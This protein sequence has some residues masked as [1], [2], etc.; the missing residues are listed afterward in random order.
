MALLLALFM[1]V[2]N[3][4]KNVHQQDN[5]LIHNRVVIKWNNTQQ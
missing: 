3:W 4:K 2:K 1:N 5:G